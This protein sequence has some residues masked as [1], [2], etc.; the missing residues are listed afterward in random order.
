M[1][2][3]WINIKYKV[4]FVV[5]ENQK[6]QSSRFNKHFALLFLIL[7]KSTDR[8]QFVKSTVVFSKLTP[9]NNRNNEQ[10]T[11]LKFS[12]VK[13]ISTKVKKTKFPFSK[14]SNNDTHEKKDCFSSFILN[15]NYLKTHRS[16]DGF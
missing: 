12:F 4:L 2:I 1:K 15:L 3:L 9:N 6:K 14:G 16:I 13:N 5:Y 11:K 8:F 10:T 7:K